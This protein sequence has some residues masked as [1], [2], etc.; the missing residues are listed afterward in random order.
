M[1]TPPPKPR[2]PV[3]NRLSSF[4]VILSSAIAVLMALVGAFTLQSASLSAL[5]FLYGV[6][7]IAVIL[8]RMARKHSEEPLYAANTALYA[9]LLAAAAFDWIIT[10]IMPATDILSRVL[11]MAAAAPCLLIS[12]AQLLKN[13]RFLR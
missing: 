1:Y 10:W 13:A 9:L 6:A 7:L 2:H 12:I 4:A 8:Y 5:S 11:P 3:L